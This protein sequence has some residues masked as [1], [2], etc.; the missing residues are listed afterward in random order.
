MATPLPLANCEISGA[1]FEEG[2]QR[3]RDRL[4][5][6]VPHRSLAFPARAKGRGLVATPGH[7]VRSWRHRCGL[8][9]PKERSQAASAPPRLT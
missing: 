8:V 4:I 9:G 6:P 2:E 1:F 5:G 7:P 3:Q